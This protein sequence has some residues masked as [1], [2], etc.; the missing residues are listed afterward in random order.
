MPDD[1]SKLEP[2]L[3][4]PNRTVKRHCADDSAETSVKVG[5]RQANIPK[6]PLTLPL[7]AFFLSPLPL[8][9]L[10]HCDRIL[11]PAHLIHVGN[12][13]RCVV[14]SLPLQI[15][16]LIMPKGCLACSDINQGV[17]QSDCV[18]HPH[19]GLYVFHPVLEMVYPLDCFQLCFC[20]DDIGASV[21]LFKIDIR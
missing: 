15:D 1:H 12:D 9:L 16:G 17:C 7:R 19:S 6:K 11:P 20:P 8:P 13:C 2:P 5:Y 4:I 21:Q 14:S 3:P 10:A 18:S